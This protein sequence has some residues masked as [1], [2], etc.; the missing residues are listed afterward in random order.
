MIVFERLKLFALFTKHDGFK[1][2]KEWRVVYLSERDT[3]KKLRSMLGYP[4]PITF[5][6][7]RPVAVDVS[8]PIESTLR[9]ARLRSSER[10]ISL[11]CP[12]DRA[13]R[14]SFV[15][16]SVSPSRMKSSDS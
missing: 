15:T 4:L 7:S 1:E 2:E 14:S 8:S 10:V 16:T 5:S 13:S 3:G 6:M 9:F 11:R 12:M